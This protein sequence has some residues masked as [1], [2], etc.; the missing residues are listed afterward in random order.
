M[1]LRSLIAWL[2]A[3]LPCMAQNDTLYFKNNDTLGRF[4]PETVYRVLAP[5]PNGRITFRDYDEQHRLRIVGNANTPRAS[6]REGDFTSYDTSGLIQEKG[7]FHRGFRRGE[8]IN[9]FIGT[10]RKKQVIAYDSI[11]RGAYVQQYDSICATLVAEG[12]LDGNEHKSGVWKEYYPC[13]A[14]LHWQLLFV[15]N[16]R[17][18]EQNEFYPNG[19]CKR[20]EFIHR[21]RVQQGRMFDTNGK[22][23]TYYP[24]VIYPRFP[25]KMY[26]KLHRVLRNYKS[27][28]PSSPYKVNLQV[29]KDGT[30]GKIRWP[31]PFVDVVNKERIE[32]VL[33]TCG[34][35]RPFRYENKALDHWISIRIW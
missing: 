22:K 20:H 35:W 21:G 14:T 1:K 17:Q 12:S 24:Q 4:C 2:M 3:A 13:T 8:W 29:L 33:R 31:E 34:R 27:A 6:I 19:Q 7:T 25:R 16:R 15:D 26:K 30:L 32:Q 23:I 11:S 9:Y 28:Q 10:Q 5:N 18:G